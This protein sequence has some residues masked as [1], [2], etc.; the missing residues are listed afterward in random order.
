MHIDPMEEETNNGQITFLKMI[1]ALSLLS[2]S[3]NIFFSTLVL[4]KRKFQN[5]KEEEFYFFILNCD[6][7]F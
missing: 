5:A 1:L 3:I 2:N 7:E 4:K 6:M